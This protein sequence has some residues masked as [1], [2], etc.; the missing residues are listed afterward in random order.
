MTAA[1]P[2]E[3]PNRI[4]RVLTLRDLLFYGI[5]VI[6][7]TAPLPS[8]G[9]VAMVAHGHVA[10]TILIGMFAMVL[11]AISY[12]RMA[13]AYPSAGSAYTY[14]GK[15]LN[16]HLGFLTGWSIVLERLIG[17]GEKEAHIEKAN[18]PLLGRLDIPVHGRIRFQLRQ[19][20]A[21]DGVNA[22]DS[23]L[24]GPGQHVIAGLLTELD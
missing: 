4:R 1:A 14:V 9:V 10:A 23:R 8:F 7:P 12:G 3:K 20:G 22:H 21:L 24:E 16:P 18:V 6:Q 19:F 5:I 13:N 15:E 11:T 2:G 17:D